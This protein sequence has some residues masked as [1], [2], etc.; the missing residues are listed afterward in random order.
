MN[1]LTSPLKE[2]SDY[3]KIY[4]TLRKKKAVA[5][6]GCSDS[7]KINLAEAFSEN[8][9]Y[10]IIATYS[11]IRVKEIAEDMRLYDDNVFT[12]PS[13]DLIF[14]QA[15][16]HGNKLV[17]ERLKVLRQ[18]TENGPCTIVTTFDTLMSPVLPIEHFVSG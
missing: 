9:D 1:I 10:R 4:D 6:S 5:V 17:T 13:K 15:D 2:L 12:Y 18:L 3:N 7:Q 8:A 11:D 16:I 14:Y